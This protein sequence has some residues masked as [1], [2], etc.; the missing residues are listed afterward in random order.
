MSKLA[1]WAQ[2]AAVVVLFGAGVAT[3]YWFERVIKDGV[4]ADLQL[5]HQK[6]YN[7]ALEQKLTADARVRAVEAEKARAISQLEAAYTAAMENEKITNARTVDDLRA[8]LARLRVSTVAAASACELSGPGAG[9]GSGH[10]PAEQTLAPAVAARL[11]GRYADYNAVVGQLALCQGV[12]AAD[13]A[14]EH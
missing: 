14:T 3:G 12:V 6:V 9:A 7:K 8:G 11:A 2:V 13:R 4:I 10:G 5:A 1:P